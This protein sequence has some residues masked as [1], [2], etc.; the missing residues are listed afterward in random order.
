MEIPSLESTDST[1]SRRNLLKL[2]VAA[3]A[4]LA[5]GA[6]SARAATATPPPI[7]PAVGPTPPVNYKFNLSTYKPEVANA[8]GSVTLCRESNFPVVGGNAAAVY[9]LKLKP[10]ALREPHWHP[11]CW[12]FDV[13][14]AGTAQMTIVAPNGVPSVFTLEPGEVA[15]V[16]QG[17]VHSI[18]DIGTVDVVIPIVFNH[19][20]PSDIGLSTMWGGFDESQ[21]AQ[22]FGVPNSVIAA[23]PSSPPGTSYIAP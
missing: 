2:A 12:E 16:P 19:E 21:F 4:G 15:F 7:V 13:V 10:G 1:A 5:L 3:G 20:M 6:T 23:I 18:K 8:G 14:V 11:N 9:L 22:T 17:F